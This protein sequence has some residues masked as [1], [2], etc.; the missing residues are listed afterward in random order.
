MILFKHR[1]A[2]KYAFQ[3]RYQAAVA[4]NIVWAMYLTGHIGENDLHLVLGATLG[5]AVYALLLLYF[6][7]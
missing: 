6:Y 2:R 7:L 3:A 4:I 1:L 5:A